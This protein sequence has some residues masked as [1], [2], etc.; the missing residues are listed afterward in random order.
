M[1][2]R[3]REGGLT[4]NSLVYFLPLFLSFFW[5][6]KTLRELNIVISLCDKCLLR[7]FI[8]RERL[9]AIGQSVA[10]ENENVNKLSTS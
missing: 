1:C 9:L 7:V 3:E 6:K 10:A 8:S 4:L 5:G 2:V